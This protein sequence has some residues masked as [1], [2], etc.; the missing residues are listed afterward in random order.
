MS[1]IFVG[2]D[3]GGRAYFGCAV[4]RMF[5]EAGHH[6]SVLPG[7]TAFEYIGRASFAALAGDRVLD[8]AGADLSAADLLVIV[9]ASARLLGQIAAHDPGE[10]L[11]VVV[12]AARCPVLIVPAA[13]CADWARPETAAAVA[14]LRD[15]GLVVLEPAAELDDIA[16]L[17]A[18]LCERRNALARDLIGRRVIIT[19]G[20]TREPLDPVRFMSNRSSGKQGYALARLAAQ[21]GAEVTLIGGPGTGL[22]TPA[23]VES[24]QATTAEQMRVEVSK[25][26]IDADA[27]IMAAAVADF[28]PATVAVSKI[29]KGAGEPDSVPLTR[30]PDILAGLVTAREA[31]E[32]AGDLTVVGFAAET[33]DADGDVLTH[34]RAKLARKGCDLLVVNAVGDGLAFEVDD[35]A[36]HLL[37][38][39]G[40]EQAL[41]HGSKHL[42]ASRVLDAVATLL[43]RRRP[44]PA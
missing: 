25:Y 22:R 6:I 26:A 21:R 1:H 14:A 39:D 7:A 42:L 23:A 34:G 43:D 17:A 33:G 36:G 13:D 35:N 11:A 28:R 15:R 40:A 27:V 29:K 37:W 32:L 12:A 24:V 31:G 10:P 41:P 38:R 20:G 4:L 9:P 16:P 18:L 5:A 2:V 3:G 30:N 44:R 19:A 8:P